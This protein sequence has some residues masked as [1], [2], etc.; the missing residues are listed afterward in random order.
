[1]EMGFSDSF[2]ICKW[3]PSLFNGTSPCAF[4]QTGQILV[5]NRLH[6]QYQFS[7]LWEIL[8]LPVTLIQCVVLQ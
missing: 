3:P 8:P 2:G 4:F 7:V 6:L 5:L 1:M